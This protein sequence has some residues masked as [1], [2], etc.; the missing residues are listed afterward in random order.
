MCAYVYITLDDKLLYMNEHMP[1][2]LFMDAC[3]SKTY[4]KMFVYI[5]L[6]NNCNI[7]T[8]LYVQTLIGG[9]DITVDEVD[10]GNSPV[11]VTFAAR[12]PI[13]TP[14]SIPIKDDQIFEPSEQ[15]RATFELPLAFMHLQ[16]GNQSEAVVIIQE[17]ESK[18]GF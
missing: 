10:Y 17:S 18:S 4:R 11:K 9:P 7:L 5:L 13:S 3:Y 14:V 1:Y 12:Q 2:P 15:L 8:V 16:K 6:Y